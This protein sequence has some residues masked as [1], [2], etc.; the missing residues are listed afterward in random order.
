MQDEIF[1]SNLVLKYIRLTKIDIWRMEPDCIKPECPEPGR[2]EPNQ[3]LHSPIIMCI[4]K[5]T[6]HD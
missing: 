4:Q 5:R 6:E 1:S 3:D 2:A